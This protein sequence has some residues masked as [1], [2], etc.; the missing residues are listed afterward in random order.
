MCLSSD[1]CFCPPPP[2][3]PPPPCQHRSSS[4]L[5]ALPSSLAKPPVPLAAASTLAPHSAMTLWSL[6]SPA[7]SPTSGSAPTGGEG[8]VGGAGPVVS[9]YPHLSVCLSVCLTPPCSTLPTEWAEKLR[10][11]IQIHG[12]IP[13]KVAAPPTYHPDPPGGTPPFG[14]LVCV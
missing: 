13:V 4:S 11:L 2:H 5:H 12:P 8:P 1:P 6:S 7:C 3:P 9:T 14:G 10:A